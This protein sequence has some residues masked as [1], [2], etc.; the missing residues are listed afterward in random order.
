MIIMQ[1]ILLNHIVKNHIAVE[2]LTSSIL[3]FEFKHNQFWT[4][5]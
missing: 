4:E 2:N 3:S 5:I 1:L